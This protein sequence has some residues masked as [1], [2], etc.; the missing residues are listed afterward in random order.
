VRWLDL[1]DAAMGLDNR[2][3]KMLDAIMAYPSQVFEEGAG[4]K[5]KGIVDEGR[6]ASAGTE[7][8]KSVG[9][10]QK[11]TEARGKGE[12]PGRER[13]GGSRGSSGEPT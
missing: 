1:S 10:W 8:R 6:R 13:E 7:V 11:E 9:G 4:E 3:K 2:R 12:L 5:V